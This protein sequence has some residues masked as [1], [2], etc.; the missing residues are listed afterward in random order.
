[1]PQVKKCL[2]MFKALENAVE[3][4]TGT[5]NIPEALRDLGARA[6]DVTNAVAD[7]LDKLRI[8]K[9]SGAQFSETQENNLKACQDCCD[10]MRSKV[11]AKKGDA[12]AG[13]GG[14]D[15]NT[16]LIFIQLAEQVLKFIHDLRHPPATGA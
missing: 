2:D 4:W 1:M 5:D 15:P 14:F 16:I 6:Q 13:A 10:R 11:T 12:G 8:K 9:G 3:T 7:M